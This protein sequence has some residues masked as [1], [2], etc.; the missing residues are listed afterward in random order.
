VPVFREFAQVLHV[1]LGDAC[2]L[3]AAHDAV[4]ERSGEKF[5]ENA[6][7]VKSHNFECNERQGALSF[8]PQAQQ[9]PR[10]GSA[11]NLAPR[12]VKSAV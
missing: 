12:I 6:D 1:N 4:V 2:L 9:P 3:R 11:I 8:L 10:N 7:E 5:R